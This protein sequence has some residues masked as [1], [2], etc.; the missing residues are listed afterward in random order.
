MII[1]IIASRQSQL[2]NIIYVSSS[3]TR[4][5]VRA[6]VRGVF[7]IFLS[8]FGFSFSTWYKCYTFRRIPI[9]TKRRR[10]F[11]LIHPVTVS[12]T[13]PFQISN[14]CKITINV[15]EETYGYSPH[16][17]FNVFFVVS[18]Q[19]ETLQVAFIGCTKISYAEPHSFVWL[20]LCVR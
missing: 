11:V 5:H 17:R 4:Y 16:I 14:D 10:F 3:R 8:Y 15:L 2:T 12:T 1:I 20:C 13:N 9:Q 7:T 19:L 18:A 6:V